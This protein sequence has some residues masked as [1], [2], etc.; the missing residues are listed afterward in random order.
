MLPIYPVSLRTAAQTTSSKTMQDS[1]E[2]IHF[3]D[4]ASDHPF[5]EKVWRCRSERAD[6]FLSVAASSFE[7]AIT[8]LGGKS[9]LTLR[10]PETVATAFDCPAEGE[11]VC[12]RFKAGTFMPWFPPGSLRDH[13]DVTLPSAAS[14]SFWLNGSAMEYPDFDNAEIFVKRLAKSGILLRDS[15]V[16]DTL[17]RRPA[18]LSLR[19]A[20]RHFLRS[21]GISYATFRQ[22]ER[23]RYATSLLRE[24]MSILDVVN[25]AG[26]FDQAHL[27]RSVRRLIGETPGKIIQGQKQLSFL[28]KTSH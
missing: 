24:G 27:T 21:T 22:I 14:S 1:R 26:Y 25:L 15:I 9:F 23:A 4:R 17:L 12:I 19:S 3:E 8:R 20:Q 10:G 28:Y 13:N 7:M 18:E 16:E 2:F 11:W 6:S 5:V